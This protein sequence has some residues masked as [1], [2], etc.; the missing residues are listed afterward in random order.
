MICIRK[1]R[2]A[3][4]LRSAVLAAA[5]TG[6]ALAD[7]FCSDVNSLVSLAS[8]ELD[9]EM[10]A[11]VLTS[12]SDTKECGFSDNLDGNRDY[13]CMWES[14][15][16]DPESYV[17]FDDMAR[18]LRTCFGVDAEEVRDQPVNHPDYYD[19]VSFQV[20]GIEIAVSIK[21]KSALQRTFAFIRIRAANDDGDAVA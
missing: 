13:H 17:R 10:N 4:T 16:R 8:Q 18:S 5:V 14:V 3:D 20:K 12:L 7:E 11:D 15:Y 9:Q 1:N 6:P 19:Q 2:L 21:D